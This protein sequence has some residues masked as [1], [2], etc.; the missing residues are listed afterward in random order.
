MELLALLPLAKS[1]FDQG[2][3]NLFLRPPVGFLSYNENKM[4]N[5]QWI[6]WSWEVWRLW[7]C[8]VV[9]RR[10]AA[11]EMMVPLRNLLTWAASK[12]LYAPEVKSHGRERYGKGIKKMPCVNQ[13]RWIHV[14]HSTSVEKWL[15]DIKME[16][17]VTPR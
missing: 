9:C 16:L 10:Q 12:P 3:L 6:L 7:S 11:K 1:W 5:N 8:L 13:G 14:N 15:G 2:E 4:S 17:D